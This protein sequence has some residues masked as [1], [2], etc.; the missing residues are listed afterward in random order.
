MKRVTAF[1]TR[2]CAGA[3]QK[4]P[5]LCNNYFILTKIPMLICNRHITGQQLKDFDQLLDVCRQADGGLP[6]FYRH[7]LTQK[8]DT[9]SNVLYYEK[10]RLVA[11]LSVYF[12]YSNAC[13]ISLLVAPSHRRQGLS[14]LLLETILPL[15]TAKQMDFVI[16]SMPSNL[17]ASWLAN[18]GFSYQ[19]TEYHMQR[20]G[21]KPIL[22]N[23]PRLTVRKAEF[24]D[25][26]TLCAIDD[27]CFKEGQMSV[28]SRFITLLDDTDYSIFVALL[29]G[30]PVGK[31]HI[32]WQE[33]HALFSD[34]AILPAYQ[35]Q[36]LGSELL[37][38]CINHAL[39]QG[40]DRQE[41]DVE[42]TNRGALDLYLR[43]GFSVLY[44]H[45]YW[46]IPID[47][48]RIMLVSSMARSQQ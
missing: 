30:K 40:K 45:D 12:F 25:V 34:I 15:L 17:N 41:L 35:R 16:F 27:A 18:S 37:A 26:E 36:G 29:D 28:P 21:Y 19:Q 1:V 2:H 10:D 3:S 44:E 46:F 43:H 5:N 13:E 48:L 20:N 31:A 47:S 7:I 8:R 22:L 4:D 11:F 14:R 9:E 6:A 24:N 42:T 39:T 33:T 38:Y 23:Q 32:R